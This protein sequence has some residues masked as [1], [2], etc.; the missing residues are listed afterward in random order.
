MN[1][2]IHEA[3]DLARRTAWLYGII[4]AALAF[5]TG[6]EVKAYIDQGVE[7]QAR[8]AWSASMERARVAA[9]ER[10]VRLNQI[11]EDERSHHADALR[12][13]DTHMAAFTSRTVGMRNELEIMLA[14]SRRS[15]EACTA[16]AAG[17]AEAVGALL[18][19]VGEGAGLLE[20]AQREN[21][22][23]AADN[24]KLATQVAGWQRFDAERRVQRITVTAAKPGR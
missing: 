12:Q 19:A 1:E 17:I 24:R 20:A 14:D 11:I 23:R 18:D 16:R 2:E 5:G 21:Q 10:E 6:L 7:A 9:A 15:G 13:R 22:Q 3:R 4:A 8:A